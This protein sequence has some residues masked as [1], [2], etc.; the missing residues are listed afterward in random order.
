LLLKESAF[1]IWFFNYRNSLRA[2]SALS[3]H[4]KL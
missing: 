4:N 2:F 3:W 1:L